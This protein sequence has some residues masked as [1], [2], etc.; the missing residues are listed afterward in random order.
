[1]AFTKRHYEVIAE[2]I[3]DTFADVEEAT[4]GNKAALDALR[5]LAQRMATVFANDNRMFDK[6]RFLRACGV[7]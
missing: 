6:H 3:N 5:E 7:L 1:M 4:D 2:L